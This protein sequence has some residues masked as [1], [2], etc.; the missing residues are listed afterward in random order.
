MSWERRVKA[1][2]PYPP[3]N[4][5][6]PTTKAIMAA[7]QLPPPKLLGVAVPANLRCGVAEE[8]GA[9]ASV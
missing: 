8:L 3:P 1:I 9:S 6:T 7:L 4:T 5:L 2:A